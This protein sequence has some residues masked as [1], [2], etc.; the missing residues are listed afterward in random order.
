MGISREGNFFVSN[1]L[2]QEGIYDCAKWQTKLRRHF[3]G[4][5]LELFVC[6][7]TQNCMGIHIPKYIHWYKKVKTNLGKWG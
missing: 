3:L 4:V 2:A 7:Y 6:F 5:T 1:K